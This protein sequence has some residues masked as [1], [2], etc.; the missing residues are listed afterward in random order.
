[1]IF[2]FYVVNKIDNRLPLQKL[3]LIC[4]LGNEK[5]K[6]TETQKL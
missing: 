4:I 5:N 3:P 2:N 1:M 6:N